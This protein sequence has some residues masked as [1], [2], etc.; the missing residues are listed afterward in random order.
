MLILS[1]ALLFQAPKPTLTPARLFDLAVAAEKSRGPFAVDVA[2]DTL[3]N[4]VATTSRYR[5]EAQPPA[6]AL[7]L[8]MDQGKVALA[9]WLRG[10]KLTACD[11]N[12]RE[13]AVRAAPTS[14]GLDN[15]L[16]AVIGEGIDDAIAVQLNPLTLQGFFAPF[17]KLPGW[18]IGLENGQTTLRRT[19]SIEGGRNETLFEFRPDHQLRKVLILGPQSKLQWTFAYLPAP[20]RVVYAPPPGST[21]VPSLSERPSLPNVDASAK[22]AIEASLRAY[23][24]LDSV[25]FTVRGP[26][27]PIQGW[28]N[29]NSFKEI[30]SRWTWTY[31]G[32]ILT[33]KDGRTGKGYRGACKPSQ[34][35]TYLKTIRAPMEPLLQGLLLHRNPLMRWIQAVE[36][37]SRAGSLTLAGAPADIIEMTGADLRVTLLIRRDNHLIASVSSQTLEQGRPISGVQRD[38]TYRSV[39]KAI[40]GSVFTLSVARPAALAALGR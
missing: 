23:A 9:F 31:A 18:R 16:A 37:V 17:R 2:V 40:P 32:G 4:K 7:L 36:K 3:F 28:K 10:G 22:P 24:R 14:G 1:L 35:S 38:F 5:L 20:K 26:D 30:Q 8:K 39:G 15:R 27:G 12:A 19:V 29:G 33:L 13:I 11:P 6:T 21:T 34:V 25:A